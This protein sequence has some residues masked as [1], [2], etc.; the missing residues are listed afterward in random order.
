MKH[1][2]SPNFQAVV[3][4]AIELDGFEEDEPEHFTTTGFGH[5]AVLGIADKV[6]DAVQKG[7]I[8][9]FFLIGGMWSRQ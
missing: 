9:D 2:R 1:V 8:K 3:D 4:K 7:Q 6:I 5:A